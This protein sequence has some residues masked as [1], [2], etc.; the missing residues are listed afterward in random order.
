MTA[1]NPNAVIDTP[2]VI[3]SVIA[4]LKLITNLYIGFWVYYYKGT[5]LHNMSLS[6][7]TTTTTSSYATTT[8]DSDLVYICEICGCVSLSW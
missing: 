4:K 3:I 8:S 1:V 6:S 2:S 5:E 7:T